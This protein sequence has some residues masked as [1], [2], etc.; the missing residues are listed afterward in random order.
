MAVAIVK[1]QP[2]VDPV[3]SVLDGGPHF[4][5]VFLNNLSHENQIGDNAM[6]LLRFHRNFMVHRDDTYNIMMIVI[7]RFLD[8][9]GQVEKDN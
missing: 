2:D 8:Y 4:N 3:Q 6:A 1:S 7:E 9:L 5:A